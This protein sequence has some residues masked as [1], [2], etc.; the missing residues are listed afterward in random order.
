M[1]MKLAI[2]VTGIIVIIGF[3][4]WQLVAYKVPEPKYTVVRADQAIEIRQYPELT[5]A[6]VRLSG[7]RYSSIKSG[8]R[9]L[10]DYIFGNNKAKHTI[11]MTAPVMQQ[12]DQNGWIIN[13]VMPAGYTKKTLPVP[14]NSSVTIKTLTPRQYAVIRFSGANSDRNIQNHTQ[15]LMAYLKKENIQVVGAPIFAFYNPPW[16]LTFLRRNEVMVEIKNNI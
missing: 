9:L 13:F 16:I 2:A 3:A 4:V 10:A 1:Y 8:F 12:K 5:I 15:Q 6:E 7:E 11:A 14:E